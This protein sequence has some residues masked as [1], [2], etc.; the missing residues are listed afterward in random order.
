MIA[1]VFERAAGDCPSVT[2]WQNSRYKQAL[3][4]VQVWVQWRPEA[5][6]LH[7]PA[8]GELPLDLNMAF[9]GSEE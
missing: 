1:V 6:H 4:R 5:E 8:D 7:L 9:R 2:F 3:P